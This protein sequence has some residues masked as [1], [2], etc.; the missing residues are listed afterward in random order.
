MA[1]QTEICSFPRRKSRTLRAVPLAPGRRRDPNPFI[2]RVQAESRL[3]Q[4]TLEALRSLCLQPKKAAAKQQIVA[5]GVRTGNLHILLSGWASRCRDFA[6]GRRQITALVL[7]GDICDIEN[8]YIETPDQSVEA[9]TPCEFATIPRLQLKELMQRDAGLKEAVGRLAALEN[10]MQRERNASLGQRQAL[11]RTAHLLCELRARLEA[12]GDVDGSSCRVPLTQVQLGE[13]LGLTSIHVNRVLKVLRAR[14]L[15]DKR[16]DCLT[17]LDWR[18]LTS[19][20]GF[21]AAY[22]HVDDRANAGAAF[23]SGANLGLDGGVDAAGVP[24]GRLDEGE[25]LR[26]RLSNFVTVA[27]S[28][29]NLS[30]R[31]DRP[32]EEER[33]QLNRRLA[34]MGGAA[35][36]L[37]RGKRHGGALRDAIHEAL[38][39]AGGV[40]PRIRCNGP[41]LQLTGQAVMTISLALH[42]L[43][44]N[45]LKYGALSTAEG[46]VDLF[47]EVVRRDPGDQLWMQW[48]EH[49]G[50]AVKPP[51][52]EGFGTHLVTQGTGRALG[53]LAEVDY[54]P[55]GLTWVLT[56]PLARI[57]AVQGIGAAVSSGTDDEGVAGLTDPVACRHDRQTEGQAFSSFFAPVSEKQS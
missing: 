9:L 7:P 1:S 8:L 53:G 30:I 34:A 14:D 33:V 13:V 4:G 57:A 24:G 51:E 31:G 23:G 19:L 21:S 25:E 3:D 43:Q 22:L 2:D 6:S 32:L 20:A 29:V 54:T 40:S 11:E 45:A 10:I 17:I 37:A 28:L 15:V 12:N 27:Q 38:Q 41:D 18:K 42:E 44:T 35:D 5:D 52:S 39:I 47:W 55:A 56:A 36:V 16:R 46:S 50:P 49:D 48:S 26:D